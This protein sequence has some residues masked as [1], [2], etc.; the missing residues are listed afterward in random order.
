MTPENQGQQA[1]QAKTSST[2]GETRFLAPTAWALNA[3]LLDKAE[4]ARVAD[5]QAQR[6]KD[7][8]TPGSAANSKAPRAVQA[9]G[10]RSK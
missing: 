7:D 6:T 3:P 2:A 1:G 9:G 10:A 5:Q 8:K 4:A